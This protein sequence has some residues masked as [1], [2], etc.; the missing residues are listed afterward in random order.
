VKPVEGKTPQETLDLQAGELVTVKSR[1]EIMGTLNKDSRNRGLYFDAEMVIFCDKQYRVNRR[2]EKIIDEPTGKMR[3]FT[4]DCIVLDNVVCE[5]Y[6][7]A[8]CPRKIQAYWRE[9]WLRRVPQASAKEALQ[10]STE[11]AVDEQET[12]GR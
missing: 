2:I 4:S 12:V 9:I 5:S 6:Y 7:H 1:D 8:L 3:H 10:P 11:E